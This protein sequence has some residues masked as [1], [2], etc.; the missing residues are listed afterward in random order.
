M[1]AKQDYD[2]TT[3]GHRV[4]MLGDNDSLSHESFFRICDLAVDR[5][6][7][8]YVAERGNARLQKF[9]KNGRF[10]MT[11]GAA[12]RGPGEFYG[13]LDLDIDSKGNI[14]VLDLDNQRLSKFSPNGEFITSIQLPRSVLSM[15]ME[16][17]D[18]ILILVNKGEFL[19]DRYDENLKYLRS[20]VEREALQ[21]KELPFP[22]PA[23][24]TCDRK[25]YIYLLETRRGIVHKYDASGKALLSWKVQVPDLVEN[26]T[27]RNRRLKEEARK[28]PYMMAGIVWVNF[29]ELTADNEGNIALTYV[30]DLGE[31]DE[32]KVRYR[33]IIY[34]YDS[35]GHFVDRI[36]AEP[37]PPEF[38]WDV[39]FCR[40][41]FYACSSEYVT[42]Y[43]LD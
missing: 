40:N 26:I 27:M 22:E 6:C 37:D 29:G 3:Y 31:A 7:N 14:Y 36:F 11:I 24:F 4:F 41:G 21:Q 28:R 39:R 23:D 12:G 5:D 19:F 13:F 30:Y 17:D 16:P 33:G 15:S 8:L 18:N 2:Q 10:V 38:F 9:D 25:G 1:C 20:L 43:V 42:K 35:K 32:G 34:R